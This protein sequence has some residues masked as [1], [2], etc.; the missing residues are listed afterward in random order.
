M[1]VLFSRKCVGRGH[2]ML[3]MRFCLILTSQEN[4]VRR[5]A[6]FHDDEACGCLSGLTTPRPSLQECSP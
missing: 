3:E 2:R 5:L 1:P 4:I 6:V